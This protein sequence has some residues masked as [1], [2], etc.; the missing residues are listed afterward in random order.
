MNGLVYNRISEMKDK[1]P[2]SPPLI[3]YI[4]HSSIADEKKI[5]KE[6]KKKLD[7]KNPIWLAEAAGIPSSWDCNRFIGHGTDM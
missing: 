3:I 4:Q 1:I 5:N 6:K 2:P 7:M